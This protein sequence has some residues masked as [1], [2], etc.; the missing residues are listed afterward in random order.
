MFAYCDNNPINRED[1][2]GYF[3]LLTLMGIGAVV[4]GLIDYAGQ[5]IAN[6][7]SGMSG[8]D[9]WT[10]V[11]VG[12]IAAAAFSGAISAVPGNAGWVDLADAVGSNVIEYGV[13][14]IVNGDEFDIGTVGQEILSDYVTSS[15]APDF[16]P[17]GDVPEFIRDIKDE[18]RAF[19]VKGTKQLEKFRD[20][21]QVSTI[22]INGFNSDTNS[23][24][25]EYF[26]VG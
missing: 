15:F 14:A 21:S 1:P 2:Y 22:I 24:L 9:M 7:N 19:G 6:R 16:L 10:S 23:K 20:F 25:L 12:E 8:P 17:T 4:G 3:G 5:V 18:A 26:G 11:N 13:N